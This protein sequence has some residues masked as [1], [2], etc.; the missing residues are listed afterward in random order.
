MFYL[1]RF[2]PV[3]HY[4]WVFEPSHFCIIFHFLLWLQN[5]AKMQK[6]DFFSNQGKYSKMIQKHEKLKK[7]LKCVIATKKT[8]TTLT[9]AG[10]G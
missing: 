7:D 4:V 3:T 5:D 6:H 8:A 2:S 1:T 9:I 10:A